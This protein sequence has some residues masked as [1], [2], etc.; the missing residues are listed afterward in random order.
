MFSDRERATWD[1]I[2][3]QLLAEDP[4]FVHTF[5][6]PPEQSPDAAPNPTAERRVRRILWWIAAGLGV[7]MLLFVSVGGALLVAMV[8]LVLWMARF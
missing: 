6:A 3:D 2:Q 8:C 4:D 7:L 1:Q 5:D